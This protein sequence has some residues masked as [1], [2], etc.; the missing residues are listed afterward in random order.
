MFKTIVASLISLGCAIAA[1]ALLGAADFQAGGA[2]PL[3]L[4]LAAGSCLALAAGFLWLSQQ[5]AVD[6]FADAILDEHSA[7]YGE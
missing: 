6:E 7:T 2:Q 5:S 1:G 4:T 3:V